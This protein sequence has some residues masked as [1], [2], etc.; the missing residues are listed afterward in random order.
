MQTACAAFPFNPENESRDLPAM[1]PR[2][3]RA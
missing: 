3:R 1:A 2:R